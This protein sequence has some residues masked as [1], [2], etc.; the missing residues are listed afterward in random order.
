MS[1]ISRS[2]QSAVI[3]AWPNIIYDLQEN[4]ADF[5]EPVYIVGGAVRDAYLRRPINDL[6]LATAG[7]GIKLARRIANAFKGDF[8]PLDS[9]RDVGRAILNTP[10]G[11]LVI[12]AAQFRGSTLEADLL[13]RD[14]TMNAMAV[15]LRLDLNAIIDPL[16]GLADL[17]AHRLR[18]CTENSLQADPIR[19][20]RAVRQSI[21]FGMRLDAQTLAAVRSARDH[22]TSVSPE[23]LRDEIFKLL[24]LPR[25]VAALRVINTLG[26]LP[27]FLPASDQTDFVFKTIEHLCA[28]WNL[29]SPE[30]DDNTVAQFAYGM[31][32]IQFGGVRARLIEL[33][34]RT[35]GAERSQRALL[36]FEALLSRQPLDVCDEQCERLRLSNQERE[37]VGKAVQA[38]R[39]AEKPEI[40]PLPVY[41]Y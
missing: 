8:Y 24:D 31:L 41:R 36:I 17:R 1:A 35:Y 33:L 13:D 14:F 26:L 7:S 25:P 21:Q 40:D 29:I 18:L 3:L 6:D 15:D 39:R 38:L 27:D 12:D 4:I 32:A 22:L 30:R 19:S 23:R 9:A 10:D 16:H 2:D 20:L 37:R 28:I 11:R 34:D 5:P